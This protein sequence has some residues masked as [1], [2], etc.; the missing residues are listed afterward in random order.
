M[1]TQFYVEFDSQYRS[2]FIQ[3]CSNINISECCNL[4]GTMVVATLFILIPAAT[5][6]CNMT[7]KW[8]SNRIY[9][10]LMLESNK[11]FYTQVVFDI[12][13]F[14][15]VKFLGLMVGHTCILIKSYMAF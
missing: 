12:L 14:D 2:N 11:L 6:R 13:T 8:K 15:C 1:Y 10:K 3:N 7:K 9:N 5:I 4:Y